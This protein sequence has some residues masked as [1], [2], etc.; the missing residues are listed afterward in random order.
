MR[1]SGERVLQQ[2]HTDGIRL[3][4]QLKQRTSTSIVFLTYLE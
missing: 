1:E 2:S 4:F 3:F